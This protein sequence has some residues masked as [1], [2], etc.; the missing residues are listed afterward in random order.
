V[1]Q[2]GFAAVPAKSL[3]N[4]GDSHSR[5]RGGSSF[6]L[7]DVPV[8]RASTQTMPGGQI[9]NLPVQ[10]LWQKYSGFRQTQI[11]SHI[12]A[13]PSP[14]RGGSRSSRTRDGMR[15]TLMALITNG[16]NA[17]GEAAWS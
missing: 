7:H 17:D 2:D 13:I 6:W 14:Q 11:T 9:S 15:W 8:K 1:D 16:A 10:S 12:A 3:S 4:I 5:A